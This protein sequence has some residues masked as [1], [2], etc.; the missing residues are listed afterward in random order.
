MQDTGNEYLGVIDKIISV[1]TLEAELALIGYAVE[2]LDPHDL[3][4]SCQQI[5]LATCSAI[6]ANGPCLLH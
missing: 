6:R 3:S 1:V 2:G 5:E 4:V